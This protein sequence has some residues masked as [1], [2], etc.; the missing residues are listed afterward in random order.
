MTWV[1]SAGGLWKCVTRT[2]TTNSMVVNSSLWSSTF[3]RPGRLRL[4]RS[5]TPSSSSRS[6]SK[7][8]SAMSLTI[9]PERAASFR[10]GISGETLRKGPQGHPGT[11]KLSFV[12]LRSLVSLLYLSVRPHPIQ[13]RL[14][15]EGLGVVGEEEVGVAVVGELLGGGD[16]MD[17]AG[18]HVGTAEECRGVDAVLAEAAASS[19]VKDGDGDLP[20]MVVEI[21]RGRAAGGGVGVRELLVGL[22][23]RSAL[24]QLEE[25]RLGRVEQ[26]EWLAFDLEGAAGEVVEGGGLQAGQEEEG[27]LTHEQARLAVVEAR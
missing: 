4:R 25:A 27:L 21:D 5:W 24:L 6:W 23:G 19:D 8:H 22:E 17:D 9:T 12:S 2:W 14:P 3:H 1:A 10:E 18:R 7:S 13:N 11:R 26:A 15:D 16:F 20:E